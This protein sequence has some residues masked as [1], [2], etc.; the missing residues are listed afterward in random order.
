[1]KEN[2]WN[3]FSE[4]ISTLSIRGMEINDKWSN[5]T[6]DI[7]KIVE[8]SFPEKECKNNHRFTLS[9]GLQK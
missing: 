7:K 3:L 6:S 4:R 5:L 8:D 1:M 2:N 9:R